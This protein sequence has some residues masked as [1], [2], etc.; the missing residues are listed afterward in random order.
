MS[1]S[2]D[3]QDSPPISD[4]ELVERLVTLLD[5]EEIEADRFHGRRK[6][7][8]VG[9]VFGGQVIAQALIAAEKTVANDRTPHSLHAYF[10]RG[11]DENLPIEYA[12]DRQFD[13]GSFS[14]RRVVASQQGVPIL[15]CATS[16]QRAEEG[17]VHTTAM[18]QVPGPADPGFAAMLKGETMAD[19][20]AGAGL[21]VPP[22]L[23]SLPLDVRF[24]R[25]R[26][27]LSIEPTSG[28]SFYWFRTR[29]GIADDPAL[30]RA[31]IAYASDFGL[32][33]SALLPH[34]M[35]AWSGDVMIVSL[36]HAIWFHAPARADEWILYHAESPWAA[37]GRAFSRGRM[38]TADG[39][40]IASTAQEGLIRRR[41]ER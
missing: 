39:R 33:T 41:R 27:P 3:T 26:S 19:E 36:D 32:L 15:N 8:G 35:Q 1:D 21:R 16:F 5:V 22:V 28:E 31:V 29:T 10:L 11:G 4:G 7:G 17:V 12:V 18:P 13:G 30:H 20:L 25:E 34:G 2:M 14:N 38:F 23:R 9:R 24:P 6:V 37:N 40:L